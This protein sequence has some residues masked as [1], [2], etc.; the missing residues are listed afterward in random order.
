MSAPKPMKAFVLTALLLNCTMVLL[1]VS[2][3]PDLSLSQMFFEVAM[4]ETGLWAIA[5]IECLLLAMSFMA[6][7]LLKND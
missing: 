7:K 4:K 1:F 3:N 6:V 2:S 5:F